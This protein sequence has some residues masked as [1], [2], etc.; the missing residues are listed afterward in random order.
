MKKFTATFIPAERSSW[1]GVS[2]KLSLM[3]SAPSKDF[4]AKDVDEALEVSA[5]LALEHGKPCAVLLKH[6]EKRAPR[7]F[8]AKTKKVRTFNLP[9]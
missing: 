8:A 6:R 2:M 9:D 5:K 3:V 1:G 4:E 7:G